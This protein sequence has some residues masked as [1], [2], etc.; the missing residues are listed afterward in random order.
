MYETWNTS[1]QYGIRVREFF[2]ACFCAKHKQLPFPFAAAAVHV[3][4]TEQIVR[5]RHDIFEV[6]D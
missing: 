3:S 6:C 1:R 4:W 2:R 5:T